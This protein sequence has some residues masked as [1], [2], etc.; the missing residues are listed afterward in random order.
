[1]AIEFHCE[2]CGAKVR[3][4]DKGGGRQGRC[5]KCSQRVYIPLPPEEVEEVPLAD[6]PGAT[7]DAADDAAARRAE[8]DLFRDPAIGERV[9]EP[10]QSSDEIPM[11]QTASRPAPA[12]EAEVPMLVIDYLLAMSDG[13]L[14]EAGELLAQLQSQ[15]DAALAQIDKLAGDDLPPDAL[16]N[17]P[18]PVLNGF[19]KQLRGQL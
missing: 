6:S 7:P 10:D 9:P 14:D 3:A 11:Q 8:M 13:E 15:R 2:H 17:I 12:G 5:P 16:A 4:P 19:L 18:S 1:M